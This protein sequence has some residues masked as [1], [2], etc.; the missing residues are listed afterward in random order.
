[1]KHLQ[2]T[3]KSVEDVWKVH[4][5]TERIGRKYYSTDRWY[6]Y[7]EYKRTGILSFDGNLLSNFYWCV[8]EQNDGTLQN[9]DENNQY[10]RAKVWT[11][12]SK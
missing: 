1:M 12:P 10:I 6:W 7:I 8:R 3:R 4:Y 5:T 11:L 9:Y 2:K